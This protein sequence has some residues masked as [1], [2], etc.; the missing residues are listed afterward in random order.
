MRPRLQRRCPPG[1]LCIG[2][3]ALAAILLAP[4]GSAAAEPRWLPLGPPAAPALARLIVDP[5][6]GD[7][8]ALSAAGLWQSRGG[9]GSW[10]SIQKGLNGRPEGFAADP[11]RP[12][13]LYAVVGELDGTCS[14]RRSDD[15]GGH[16]SVVFRSPYASFNFQDIQVDPFA[17]DTVYWHS[18]S[19]LVR[20]R[21]AGRTWDYFSVGS[22]ESGEPSVNAFAFAPD[23]AR[24]LFVSG[25]YN[26]F[27][28][29]S[30]GGAT[31]TQS[32]L[33][34]NVNP[35]TSLV[36]TRAP[37]SLYAWGGRG[38]LGDSAPCF[39][40]SDDDGAT[41]KGYLP[42]TTCAAPAIDVND[43]LTVR[44]VV[45]D[46]GA[47][48]LWV[49]HNGGET[50]TR[51]GAAP[52]CG[53]LYVLPG[54]KGLVLA[55]D[56]G[57]FR[58]PGDQSPW[59]P[60]NHGFA[61]SEIAAVLPTGRGVVAAPAQSSYS[62]EPPAIPLVLTEDGGRSWRGT[63]LTNPLALAP[64]PD[65]P[66]RLI[67][68]ALR[69]EGSWTRHA[70]VLESLDDGHTWRGVVDPQ[71]E[72]DVF[73]SLAI[74]PFEPR[75][76]YAGSV[77]GGFYRSDDGGRTWSG[78]SSGL[79]FGGCHHY[80]CE[81]NRVA[82]ILS[83][84]G[85]S[86]SVAILFESQIYTSADSGFNWRVRGPTSTRQRYGS[87]AALARDPQGAL[88]AIGTST[89]ESLG[90]VYRSTDDGVT[91]KRAGRLPR[92]TAPGRA[93]QVTAFVATP[94]GLFVGTDIFGVLRSADGGRTWKALND[95]LPLPAVTSLAA[96]PLDATRLYATVPQNGVYAIQVQ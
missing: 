22:P 29:T 8:Y 64:D 11:R 2:A 70:R 84:A 51:A 12:G 4:A 35:P 30:D 96:D 34:E 23:Q 41:W 25:G 14:V 94:A 53:D 36:A 92:L 73:S 26:L 28:K 1:R 68:S 47:P 62:N 6:T 77:Y 18:G 71:L 67:A 74:D 88:L 37:R 89:Q 82:A 49:S 27:F 38:Y 80:Y 5:G 91:W 85:K 42:Y 13:R 63:P 79:R 81:T 50:W 16:W 86:G 72:L 60:A 55:T 17:T 76:L 10:R 44:I 19:T 48:Q 7:A 57:F 66:H 52:D 43:P 54:K 95:G 58:A 93:S 46:G 31:W 69:Y 65:D 3:A 59:R 45:V 39:V 33:S 40:R 24:T 20:S 32:L 78:S 21:D 90:T 75:T 61:A 9:T 15:S 83:D 56:E 87:V